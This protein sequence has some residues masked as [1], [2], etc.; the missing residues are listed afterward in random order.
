MYAFAYMLNARNPT[1]DPTTCIGLPPQ[2]QDRS[3]AFIQFLS[4][5]SKL[6]RDIDIVILSVCPSVR[7]TLVFYQNG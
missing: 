2:T 7:N 6:T 3:A 5:V 4:R 1:I